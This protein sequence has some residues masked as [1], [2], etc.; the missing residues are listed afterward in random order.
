MVGTIL[1]IMVTISLTVVTSE[2][3]RLCTMFYV[4]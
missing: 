1:V 4:R 2:Y 3:Q